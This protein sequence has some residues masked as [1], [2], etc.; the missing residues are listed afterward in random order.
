MPRTLTRH[1]ST[2]ALALI[3][4]R[5]KI[6]GEINRLKLLSALEGGPKNVS[7][8]IEATGLQQANVSRHLQTLTDGGLVARQ[9]RGATVVYSI[10]D[11]SIFNLCRLVCG[12]IQ[13]RLQQQSNAFAA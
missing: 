4:A 8:L 3:A 10:A 11:P 2:D 9:R 6:L 5:F 13:K 7:Q 1:L 12:G